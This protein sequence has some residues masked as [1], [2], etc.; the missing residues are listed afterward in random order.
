[1]P[2]RQSKRKSSTPAQSA[3]SKKSNIEP[4]PSTSKDDKE[5]IKVL[6]ESSVVPIDKGC[7]LNSSDYFVYREKDE[8]FN[9]MLNQ[10]NILQNNNKFYTLQII[11]KKGD[12][13]FWLY[14][15][16]GRIGRTVGDSLMKQDREAAITEFKKKFRAKTGNDWNKRDAFVK[17]K[18]KYD[19]IEV[20]YNEDDDDGKKETKVKAEGKEVEKV[21]S[22]L[23]KKVQDLIQLIFDVKEW[24]RSMTELGFD[25]KK[26]PLGKLTKAQVKAGYESLKKISEIIQKPNRSGL[27][28]ACSEFYTRIPHNFG[29][30]RPTMITTPVQVKEKLQL[31]ESL[32]DIQIG[33][34]MMKGDTGE[35]IS[36]IDANYQSLNCDLNPL[37]HQHTN[38]KLIEEFITNT[39]GS[40]HAGYNLNLIDAYDVNRA[41]DNER[42]RDD[43]KPKMLLWHGSRLMNWCG[44]LGQGL[45]IAPPEAPASGYMFG[46]GVYFADMVSKSANYC[47]A[48]KRSPVA[49]LLLCEVAVGE[50]NEKK[51]A[52]YQA[53]LLPAGKHS[54]K[55]V[56]G[57]TP[58]MAQ[59]KMLDGDVTVPLGKPQPS[60]VDGAYLLYN[61]YIVYDVRQ[62]KPRFLVKV[63]FNFKY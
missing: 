14:L 5:D 34:E 59:V 16:W 63:K 37:N 47:R 6:D 15:R 20:D 22:K 44:I 13:D 51:S 30:K 3:A 19:L 11:K 49:L 2:K 39:H 54:T 1:M 8:V 33:M 4:K 26:S 29:M 38:F 42:F 53:N 35:N 43:I 50:M 58:N 45:R 52:D 41:S 32:N 31:L 62:V 24:E 56:G 9:A 27:A 23:D 36:V 46:K 40:T 55:G 25:V 10:T 7:R 28:A 60:N 61:E 12:D 57:T 17:K 21:E 48:S 18:G